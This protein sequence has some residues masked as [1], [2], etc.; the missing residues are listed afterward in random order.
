MEG[1]VGSFSEGCF[2]A[3]FQNWKTGL[4]WQQP[5]FYGKMLL[6]SRVS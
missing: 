4:L 1:A 3:A 6:L 5:F 2:Y